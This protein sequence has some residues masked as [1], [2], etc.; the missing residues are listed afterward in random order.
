MENLLPLEKTR[1]LSVPMS[2]PDRGRKALPS[3]GPHF[4]SMVIGWSAASGGGGGWFGARP[5]RLQASAESSLHTWSSATTFSTRANGLNVVCGIR[6][7]E[8][9]T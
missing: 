8:W 7:V 6:P 5:Q 1:L 3:A 2:D 4:L 9:F